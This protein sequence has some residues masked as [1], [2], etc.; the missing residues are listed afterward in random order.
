MAAG[1]QNAWDPTANNNATADSNIGWAEGQAP[2]T[3]NNSAR[4]MMAAVAKFRKDIAGML[5]TAGT[6][7]AYTLTTNE[8]LVLADGVTVACRM[9]AT[10]GAAPTLNVDSTGAVAIQGQQ[11]TAI[12]TGALVSGGIYSFT[13]YAS[14]AAWVCNGFFAATFPAGTDLL[15]ADALVPTGW[16]KV[17]TVDQGALRLLGTSGGGGG[18]GGTDDFT[19]AFGSRTIAQGN[20]PNYNLSVSGLSLNITNGSNLLSLTGGLAT[21]KDGGGVTDVLRSSN[22]SS[23]GLSGGLSGTLASG[24]SGSA[25]SFAVKYRNVIQGTKD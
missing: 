10:N 6:S 23:V 11:G 13:Y 8:T 9:S 25:M 3:V 16:T 19:T 18:S 20:L 5:L 15:F 7:T 21:A 22:L 24:G 14:S 12:P 1:V 4:A 17:T 2:S